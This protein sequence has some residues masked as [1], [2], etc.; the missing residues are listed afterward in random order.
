MAGRKLSEYIEDNQNLP[1]LLQIEY[2]TISTEI[3][4]TEKKCMNISDLIQALLKNMKIQLERICQGIFYANQL[5][6]TSIDV[7]YYYLYLLS[8]YIKSVYCGGVSSQKS[9]EVW[10]QPQVVVLL[11]HTQT[12]VQ[13]VSWCTTFT[14]KPN[15]RRS[16]VDIEQALF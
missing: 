9:W 14:Y 16:L 4:K 5:M 2:T 15:R 7:A 1:G 11:T 3:T 10:R 6:H 8:C 12:N 13:D